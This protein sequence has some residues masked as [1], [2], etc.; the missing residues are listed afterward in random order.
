MLR[1]RVNKKQLL[2][3]PLHTATFNKSKQGQN[4]TL[5]EPSRVP[6]VALVRAQCALHRPSAQLGRRPLSSGPRS[7]PLLWKCPGQSTTM[8]TWTRLTSPPAPWSQSASSL[9]PGVGGGSS[10]TWPSC[11][12]PQ[13]VGTRLGVGEEGG[14]GLSLLLS[15]S[16]PAALYFHSRLVQEWWPSCFH[17]PLAGRV[18]VC[19]QFSLHRSLNEV[20]ASV[21]CRDL[22]T[23]L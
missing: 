3:C 5:R 9:H 23:E 17:P 21:R 12:G 7:E 8:R 10:L 13:G 20:W 2:P 19:G 22:L 18:Y 14:P 4:L 15:S 11:K 6:Q 1:K 16:S